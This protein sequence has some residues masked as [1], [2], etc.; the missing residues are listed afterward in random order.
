VRADKSWGFVNIDGREVIEPRYEHVGDFRDGVAKVQEGGRWGLMGR[1][2][3][4]RANP[5]FE[6]IERP[7]IGVGLV[8]DPL[9]VKVGGRWG[10]VSLSGE[11]VIAPRFE[12]SGFFSEGMAPVKMNGLTG[13]VD[14]SGKL[15][16]EP[17]FPLAGPFSEGRALVRTER[18]RYGYIDRSG[19]QV[20]PAIYDYGI[21]FRGGLARVSVKRHWACIDRDSRV[22]IPEDL[23]CGDIDEGVL[24]VARNGRGGWAD[25]RDV[26]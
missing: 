22:V 23:E 14:M 19:A 6:E 11:M 7:P 3:Q 26:S 20:I 18:D 12:K 16:I 8:G 9:P 4:W 25:T 13:Y 21:V 2:G 24:P 17:R 5:M 15:V 10:Y 1:D